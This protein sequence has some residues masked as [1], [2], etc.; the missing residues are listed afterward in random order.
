M[1]VLLTMTIMLMLITTIMS[2]MIMMTMAAMMIMMMMIRWEQGGLYGFL[3]VHTP[4]HDYFHH[5]SASWPFS[6]SHPRQSNANKQKNKIPGFTFSNISC[7]KDNNNQTHL[8]TTSDCFKVSFFCLS[9]FYDL[10]QQ[11]KQLE[12]KEY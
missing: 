10:M 2:T 12:H 8:W 7:Q 4:R 6:L 11:K 9:L 5:N 3:V 1:M